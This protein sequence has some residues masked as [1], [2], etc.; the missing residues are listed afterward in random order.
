MNLTEIKEQCQLQYSSNNTP[1]SNICDISSEY[2]CFRTDIDDPF[3]ITLN[4]P[5]IN[6][7]Q[8][9][10][11]KIDCLS[12]LDERNRIQC[13]TFGM[14][15]FHFQFDDGRCGAYRELCTVS[16]QWI[17]GASVA[18]DAVCFHQ[19]RQFK[20]GTNSDCNSP[21]DVMCL[22]DVCLKNARCNGKIQCLQGEDEYRCIPQSKSQLDYRYEKR[23]VHFETLKLRNYPSPTQLSYKNH[24]YHRNGTDSGSILI[25]TERNNLL[26]LTVELELV[27][28]A[29]TVFATHNS[30]IKSI[31]EIVRDS[32]PT[33]TIT[34]EKHYLPFFCNRGVAV[35]YY[36]DDTIC[37]CPPSFYGSQC[38]FYSD[39]IT[40]LTHLNLSDYRLPFHKIA[41]IK[42]LTTF[43]FANEVI[44]YYEFH[45]HPHIQTDAN[46]LKETIYFLYPRL[47]QFHEMKKNKRNGTQLYTVQFE[48]F[49]LYLNDTIDPIG[50]WQ[51]PIYFDFL[52]A[53]RLSKILRLH[54]PVPSYPNG[55]CSSNPC[56]KNGLCQEVIN[57]NRSLHFCSCDSG[58]HGTRCEYYAKECNNSCSPKSIC[59]PKYRG[60]LTGNQQ[61]LCLC[62]AST[63]GNTCYLKNDICENNPCMNGGSCEVTYDLTDVNKYICLCTDSFEG[64]H[65]QNPKGMVNITF[66]LSS[67]SKLQTA[68]VVAITV[69]YNDYHIPSLDFVVRHQQ[70]YD[71]LLLH[72]QLIYS[73]KL[74][75]Y[76]PDTAV[77]KVYGS[78]YRNK[79]PD[80]YVLYFYPNQ[81]EI[82]ITTDLTS[83]NH[84]PLV[85]TLWHL[86]RALET[87]GMLEWF[88]IKFLVISQA[89]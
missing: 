80:Y 59:K 18:Y 48:A 13:G 40:I 82:N 51:Y 33:G 87:P 78:N 53:F 35:K 1:F 4:R 55:P 84:C 41:V 29:R 15:G 57:S 81:K 58:Y 25:T 65:C 28:P 16:H 43:L 12:G 32:L 89:N 27:N 83:E 71:A 88:I 37:F 45:T 10:D 72:L 8:I 38:E 2:P 34:L 79:E 46:Y 49:N 22:N 56:G 61:P 74:T 76:A 54:Y 50:V 14:L 47:Q 62:P 17:P 30:T 67:D 42:I 73:H 21:N 19:Q 75:E 11:N 44:D 7:T 60:I 24:S 5:C 64:D 20:N 63:F 70:V 39:R 26:N 86:V 77:L 85:Q 23:K 69:S 66:A 9:G 36:T 6:L 3:N 68:D 52:P 31:Y